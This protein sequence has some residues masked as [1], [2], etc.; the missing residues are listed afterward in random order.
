MWSTLPLTPD[1]A[2]GQ[3]L[4]VQRE[5]LGMIGSARVLAD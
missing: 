3:V 4:A 5:T 2:L 1:R